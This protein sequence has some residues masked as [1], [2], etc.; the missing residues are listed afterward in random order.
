MTTAAAIRYLRRSLGTPVDAL[1]APLVLGPVTGRAAARAAAGLDRATWAVR[2]RTRA[3]H[4]DRLTRALTWAD[5]QADHGG[6]TV[7]VKDTMD[8]AGMPTG[9]G[10]AT[11]RHY[12]ASTADAVARLRALDLVV[13]GKAYATELNIGPPAQALNPAFPDLSPGG[14]STGSAVSV[15]AGICDYAVATDVLGSARWPAANC[16]IAGLRVTWHP[17]RLAG[18]LPVSPSQDAIGLMARTVSD[19]RLLWRRDPVPYPVPGRPTDRPVV[20]TVANA[21]SASPAMAGAQARAV[22]ELRAAGVPVTEV[23]LPAAAWAARELAWELCAAD[24]AEVAA[25]VADR[26]GVTLSAPARASLRG[27]VDAAR[28][29]ELRAA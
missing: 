6:L 29:G 11:H 20:A 27:P 25:E 26:L 15:A 21:A 19:L 10:H 5:P 28:R 4:A 9:L 24:V 23:E 16:G 1:P 18:V 14:S 13:V 3:A 2:R 17:A 12:P 8:V 7:T 22:A